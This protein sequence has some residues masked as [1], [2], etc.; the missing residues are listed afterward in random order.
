MR[1]IIRPTVKNAL[2]TDTW[3]VAPG[4]HD[5]DNKTITWLLCGGLSSDDSS[6]IIGEFESKTLAKHVA[7]L[8]NRAVRKR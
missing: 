5:M 7:K 3:W 6:R 8:H 1:C 2:T 4:D